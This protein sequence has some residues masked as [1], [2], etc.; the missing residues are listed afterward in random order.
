M[1][2]LSAPVAIAATV[3]TIHAG[4]S[5]QR[6]IG[7]EARAYALYYDYLKMCIEHP[8]LSAWYLADASMKLPPP[9]DIWDSDSLG[10]SKYLWFV[11]YGLMAFD[12][13]LSLATSKRWEGEL[14]WFVES[15]QPVFEAIWD[16][17][18]KDEHSPRMGR[19]VDEVLR[20]SSNA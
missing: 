14:R 10:C 2:A 17:E 19:L 7:K 3:W 13:M 5:K 20:N 15:H 4:S 12:E 6:E 8:E 11:S 18:W 16:K 9:S 1:T